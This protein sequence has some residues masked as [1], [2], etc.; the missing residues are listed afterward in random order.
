MPVFAQ[1]L[2]DPQGTKTQHNST[3]VLQGPNGRNAHILISAQLSR[4]SEWNSIVS[5]EPKPCIE[6]P[7]VEA[8]F[9]LIS[10]L[11]LEDNR[12]SCRTLFFITE[13]YGPRYRMTV[14]HSR[15]C[16]IDA[17]KEK[18]TYTHAHTQQRVYSVQRRLMH[19]Y[20][21][22]PSQ[23][24]PYSGRGTHNWIVDFTESSIL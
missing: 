18:A 2:T 11:Q 15:N 14:P 16:S 6:H 9:N 19:D 8:N 4:K 13:N 3:S 23:Q 1:A 21:S 24:A 20:R 12:T 10:P 22:P 7:D 17:D 5:P